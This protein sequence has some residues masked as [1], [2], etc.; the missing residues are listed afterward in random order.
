[1]RKYQLTV[2]TKT[3]D[4]AKKKVADIIAGVLKGSKVSEE[5]LGEKQLAYEINHQTKGNY[6][7][8]LFEAEKLPEGFEKRLNSD[9]N[10]LR[11]LLANL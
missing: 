11:F 9:D 4:G 7:N 8:F 3:T 6:F 5:D 2:V 10:I 1:M